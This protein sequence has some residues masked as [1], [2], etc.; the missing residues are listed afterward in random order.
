MTIARTVPSKGNCLQVSTATETREQAVK[1]DG[2][3]YVS[4][5]RVMDGEDIL[6]EEHLTGRRE[7]LGHERL[8]SVPEG[9]ALVGE[10]AHPGVRVIRRSP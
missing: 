6:L 5:Y 3:T 9:A 7:P 4:R 1:P 10:R 8:D 2:E